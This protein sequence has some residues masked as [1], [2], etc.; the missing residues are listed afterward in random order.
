MIKSEERIYQGGLSTSIWADLHTPKPNLLAKEGQPYQI[1]KILAVAQLLGMENEPRIVECHHSK[2]V[3]LPVTCFKFGPYDQVFTYC[4]VRDN[5]HDIKLCV[6]SDGPVHIPYSLIHEEWSQERYDREKEKYQGYPSDE[7][8]E[9]ERVAKRKALLASGT[10]EWY[11]T[12]WSNGVII[13]HND[14]IY[15]AEQPLDVYCEGI[16]KLELP[17]EV[18]RA[19]ERGMKMFG[20][21]LSTYGRL[22]LVLEY[23]KGSLEKE[24]WRQLEAPRCKKES[25]PDY[26]D[27]MPLQ[28]FIDSCKSGCLIDYDGCGNYATSDQMA[29]DKTVYPSEV[30]DGDIDW[31]FSHVVWFNR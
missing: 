31:N 26:G 4:F 21:S 16:D 17:K 19:Y 7:I 12:D 22:V 30:L 5:F 25:I 27:H 11:S 3:P 1:T 28:E 10:D 15:R 13:R 8:L 14:R 2:S 29:R 18:F 20:C 23:I 24:R 6:V 9:P